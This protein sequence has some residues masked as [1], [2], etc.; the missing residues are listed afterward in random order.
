MRT[1]EALCFYEVKFAYRSS[2]VFE[3]TKR[4]NTQVEKSPLL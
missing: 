3:Q 1:Q 2:F 4:L